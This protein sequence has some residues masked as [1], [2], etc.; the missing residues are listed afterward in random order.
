M[1]YENNNSFGLQ[2]TYRENKKTVLHI[3]A[4]NKELLVEP[5]VIA[6]P[7]ILIQTA[8]VIWSEIETEQL[9]FEL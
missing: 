4:Y 5:I 3:P 7:A 8:D 2:H 1:V 9:G 6:K